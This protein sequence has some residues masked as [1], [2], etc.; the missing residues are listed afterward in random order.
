MAKINPAGSALLY[1]TN[2]GGGREDWAT[3]IA[4]DP[5]DNAYVTGITYSPNFPTQ[6]AIQQRAAVAVLYRSGDGGKAWE[7]SD[8]GLPSGVSVMAI[9]PQTPSTIYSAGDR[10]ASS[11]AAMAAKPGR[12]STTAS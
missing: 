9:D 4:L 10:A 8:N 12:Q 2:L 11:R 7:P 1:T 5:Q 3:A 6:N